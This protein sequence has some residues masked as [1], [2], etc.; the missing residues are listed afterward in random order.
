MT[1]NLVV[2]IFWDPPKALLGSEMWL[3]IIQVM[4]VIGVKYDYSELI[5]ELVVLL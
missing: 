2:K 3:R 5:K 4:R 1:P